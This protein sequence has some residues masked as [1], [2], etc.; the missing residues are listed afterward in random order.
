M[1]AQTSQTDPASGSFAGLLAA[2]T[3]SQGKEGDPLAPPAFTDHLEDD[4]T[5]L[6]YES[7][8]A[9]NARHRITEPSAA[10]SDA[11]SIQ[12]LSVGNGL[13][14]RNSFNRKTASVT[15]RLS[16]AEFAQ[17]QQRAVEA[18]LTVSAYVRSCTFEA[19]TLRAQV[20]RAIEDLR[21]LGPPAAKPFK[22]RWFSRFRR[23]KPADAS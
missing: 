6:S 21:H 15:L 14:G 5:T 7:A 10:D 16:P 8:L 20:K 22:L 4:V 1:Q 18:K 23:G 17:L 13:P 12:P 3:R 9:R 11:G 2:L 19:E